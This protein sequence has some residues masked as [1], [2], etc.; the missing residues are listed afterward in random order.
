VSQTNAL[1]KHPECDSAAD[2]SANNSVTLVTPSANMLVPHYGLILRSLSTVF[3]TQRLHVQDLGRQ[4]LLRRWGHPVLLQ[5]SNHFLSISR[6]IFIV[7]LRL[8]IKVF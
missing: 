5:N 1:S 6:L 7:V 2:G 3:Q 4:G 8:N